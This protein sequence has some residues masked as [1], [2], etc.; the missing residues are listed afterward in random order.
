MFLFCFVSHSL[1]GT[2]NIRSAA[3][4]AR[5]LHVPRL[6][7]DI[8]SAAVAKRSAKRLTLKL[9]KKCARPWATLAKAKSA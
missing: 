6:F 7:A 9:T 2:V 8:S 5:H 4:G 3:F 1:A